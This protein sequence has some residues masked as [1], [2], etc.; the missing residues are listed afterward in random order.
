M[1]R[2]WVIAPLYYD[3][4]YPDTWEKVWKYD[5]DQGVISIGWGEM[6]DVSGFDEEQLLGRI[7]ETYTE[8]PY[9]PG[10]ATTAAR[11]IHNFFHA[12]KP[13]D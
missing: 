10:A 4:S 7:A 1:V 3:S 2:F 6:R 5:L 12:V 8:D 9:A 11:M 13:G